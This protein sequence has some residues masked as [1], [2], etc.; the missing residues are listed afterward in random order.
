MKILASILGQIFD[1]KLQYLHKVY[2]QIPMCSLNA[3]EDDIT[4]TVHCWI[5]EKRKKKILQETSIINQPTNLFQ[6]HFYKLH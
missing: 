6:I 1:N 3:I 4:V 5:L 2:L